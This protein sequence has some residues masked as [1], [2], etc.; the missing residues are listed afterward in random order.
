LISRS[1]AEKNENTRFIQ[2]SLS[3]KFDEL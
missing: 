2:A 1:T 3:Q